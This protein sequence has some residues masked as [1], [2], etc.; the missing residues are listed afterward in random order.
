[1][2]VA[3]ASSGLG[4]VARGIETWADDTAAALEGATALRESVCAGGKTAC[5]SAQVVLFKGGGTGS[6]P[7]ERIVPCLR[8]GGQLGRVL[9]A[10]MSRLGGWRYGF[11]SEYQT[12]QTTFAWSLIPELRRG[13]FDIVHLQDPW[14]AWLL[15]KAHKAGRHPAKVIL[16]H[17]TEEP[18]EFLL[19]FDCVQHLAPW[20]LQEA[21]KATGGKSV[22]C[23]VWN[24]EGRKWDVEC[25]MS[26]GVGGAV[27]TPFW[28]AIPN[29]VDVQKFRPASVAEKAEAR[30]RLGIPKDA[31][32]VGTVAAVKKT[33]KR[34]DYLIREFSRMVR[35]DEQPT[36]A[37]SLSVT[38][39]TSNLPPSTFHIPRPT[40]YLLIAG[41]RTSE[42]SELVALADQL[43]PGRIKILVDQPREL[44]PQIY[45]AMDVF[46]LASLFEMMP[47]AVLE[48]MAS[49]L[50]VI[51]NRHPVLQW[52]IGEDR[53]QVSAKLGRETGA[54]DSTAPAQ[55][56]GEGLA[57]GETIDMSRDGELAG[58]V[59]RYCEDTALRAEASVA[60]RNQ[61]VGVF[62]KEVVVEQMIEMYRVVRETHGLDAESRK[63]KA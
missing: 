35:S 2:K 20:H 43:A 4:H 19:N 13:R 18:P 49:S 30:E 1:M 36:V 34:I 47:I 32:V 41:A 59:L 9:V 24:V 29:F 44:M 7:H 38:S 5:G 37:T 26:G 52:M 33:H 39:S 25:G 45:H 58:V 42:T 8:R 14:L 28:V 63:R 6:A 15:H 50:P 53:C 51:A 11:G 60:A 55:G 56:H 62:S 31:F 17:G 54:G 3:V 61:A 40:F 46:V 27:A 23:G 16:A 21:L 22:E 12:E 48:A 57:G 10:M